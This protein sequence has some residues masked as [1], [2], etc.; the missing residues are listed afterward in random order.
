VLAAA[1]GVFLIGNITGVVASGLG[2]LTTHEGDPHS[3]R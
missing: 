2:R 3:R 1:V